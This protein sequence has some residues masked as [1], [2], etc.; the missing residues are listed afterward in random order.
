MP[1][2]PEPGDR[3]RSE[4]ERLFLRLCRLHRVPVPEVNVRVGPFLVDFLW[5]DRRLVVETDGYRYHRGWHAFED[6]R[7]RDLR[8]RIL[9]YE[10][11]R[12]SFRQ[13][14]D[15]PER[16]AAVLKGAL[17]ANAGAS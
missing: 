9:G 12:L 5:R 13:V 8:L 10:V 2:G 14:V 1:L 7:T 6:D 16:V 4:L 15:E 17:S 3:T 11:I